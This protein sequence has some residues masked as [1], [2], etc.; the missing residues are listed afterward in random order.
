[1]S[2]APSPLAQYL[3]S[4]YSASSGVDSALLNAGPQTS[5]NVLTEEMQNLQLPAYESLFTPVNYWDTVAVQ[6]PTFSNYGAIDA[7]GEV[8]TSTAADTAIPEEV[9]STA[10]STA[11]PG[12]DPTYLMIGAALLAVWFLFGQGGKK[13]HRYA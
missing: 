4:G 2:T 11:V 8:V 13:G 6:S 1:M 5:S 9:V 7:A 10:L 3:Q 12:I